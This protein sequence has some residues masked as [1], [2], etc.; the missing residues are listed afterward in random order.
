MNNLPLTQ[1]LLPDQ[2]YRF[3]R[4]SKKSDYLPVPLRW[5]NVLALHLAGKSPKEIMEQ[6]GY[7]QA[8]YYR[9]LNHP[10]IQSV[11]QQLLDS[12]Q[13]EFEALFMKVV[14]NVRE[15]LASLDP[16]IQLAAQQQWFK[17][18]GKF[19]PS[20]EAESRGLTAEDVVAKLL[21]I[22]VQVNVGTKDGE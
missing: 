8:M 9:I 1:S 13:Q 6:T 17:A 3:H 21:N 11:R 16:Q 4:P 2:N 7:S 14:E 19:L 22:N 5:Y 15:Q 12:T 10:S 20:K 18:N